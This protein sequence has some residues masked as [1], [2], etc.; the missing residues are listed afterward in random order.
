[1]AKPRVTTKQQALLTHLDGMTHMLW[2]DPEQLVTTTVGRQRTE[3]IE[4]A[5][6]YLIRSSVLMWHVRIDSTLTM[7]PEAHAQSGNKVSL[8]AKHITYALAERSSL[9]TKLE[10]IKSILEV[11]TE[12]QKSLRALN[13]VRNVCAH[14][15]I[16]DNDE[17]R[18]VYKK[19]DLL[20]LA[21][22][23]EF[24]MDMGDILNQYEPETRWLLDI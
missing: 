13:E 5:I 17:G 18:L 3:Q 20:K 12:I 9:L 23:H 1:M 14:R 24:V 2:L 7:V 8:R 10:V 4:R 21:C 11:P 19:H 16:I 22:F 15:L 6:E